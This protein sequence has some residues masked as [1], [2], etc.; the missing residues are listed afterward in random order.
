MGRNEQA[1][2]EYATRVSFSMTLTRTMIYYLEQ[3]ALYGGAYNEQ[4]EPVDYYERRADRMARGGPWQE[5]FIP[6]FRSL[7][8]RG[9]AEHNGDWLL[10]TANDEQNSRLDLSWV[11]RL[12]EAGEHT[13]A[14][15]R[16]AGVSTVQVAKP[17]IKVRARS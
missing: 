14:L 10:R 11:Y 15:L 7:E 9:L 5:A 6:G 13:L 2:A 12:T 4:R 17:R 16:I 3:I 1:F 8:K